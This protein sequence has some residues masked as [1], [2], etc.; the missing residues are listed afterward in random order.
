MRQRTDYD[1]Q[2]QKDAVTVITFV[3]PCATTKFIS[4][5]IT[6]IHQFIQQNTRQTLVTG[7]VSALDDTTNQQYGTAGAASICGVS[8]MTMV[9]DGVRPSFIPNVTAT[10]AGN[11]F[12]VFETDAEMAG[13]HKVQA[14]TK[15]DR[16]PTITDTSYAE[17]Y[18]YALVDPN[19]QVEA[20]KHEVN[21]QKVVLTFEAFTTYPVDKS[22]IDI[23]HQI[24][25]PNG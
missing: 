12:T 9:L 24:T 21:T 14:V 23:T 10:S 7:F 4:K 8:S 11:S 5:T 18:L 15:F 16:Y 20:I 3:D 2:L 17:I 6:P 13:Y 19:P 25:K 1:T 22:S